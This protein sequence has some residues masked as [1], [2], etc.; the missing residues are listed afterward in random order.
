MT[1]TVPAISETDFQ[2]NVI[3]LARMF[4]WRV[5]HFRPA[6]TS[7][8]WR[9]PMQGDKGFPDLVLAKAGRVIFAELKSARGSVSKEQLAWLVD[10]DDGSGKPEV[11]VWRPADLDAIGKLLGPGG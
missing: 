10:L 7:K 11:Y 4:G 1:Q 2:N 5:A 8:G 3:A 6:K 9:T